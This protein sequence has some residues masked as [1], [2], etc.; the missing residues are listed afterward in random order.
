[1]AEQAPRN[2]SRPPP[3]H[4]RAGG[5]PER[6]ND[7]P[8]MRFDQQAQWHAACRSNQQPWPPGSGSTVFAV[9]ATA[10]CVHRI[11]ARPLRPGVTASGGPGAAR[12]HRAPRDH[13]PARCVQ[14]RG[15]RV[16]APMSRRSTEAVRPAGQGNRQPRA[17]QH[18]VLPTGDPEEPRFGGLR[19][20]LRRRPL[21]FHRRG[22][23]RA[24]VR[25]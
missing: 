20:G 17:A 16:R 14:T 1:M 23:D 12:P 7:S 3:C 9:G 25:G 21:D 4:S 22:N 15:L 19:A 6:Q 10:S 8:C 24:A 11:P 2:A 5:N 18:V 13:A